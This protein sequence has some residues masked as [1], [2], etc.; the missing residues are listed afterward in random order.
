MLKRLILTVSTVLL[1][2]VFAAAQ[3]VRVTGSVK[4]ASDGSGLPGVT[5]LEQ[6]TTNGAISDIDGNY[7]L[8]VNQGATLQF[9][10]IGYTRQLVEVNGR[11]SI[12][13]MLEGESSVLNE[14]VV[15]AFGM[16]KDQKALGY[17]VTKIDGSDLVTAKEVSVASQLAGKVPGL[18]ITRPTTGPAGSTNIVIRGLGSLSGDNRAL[19]VVDGVPINN[20]NINSA[21]MWGGIDS[22]DGLSSINPDD[23][24]SVNVLKG[25]A[26]GALY[27]ERGAQGVIL[28][29]TKKGAASDGISLE[30]TTN[31][32]IDNAAIF[33]E[34]YQS[35]YGQGMNGMKPSTR[36]EAAQNPANWGARLDG[37]PMVYFDG[38]TR[39]YSAKA[40]DDLLNYYETGQTWMNTIAM[41]GGTE[42]VNARLSLSN[43]TNTGIVPNS[44][45]D[46][47]TVNLLT[48]LKLSE[49]L[50]LEM[51]ANYIQEEA[52][53]R[54]NL[55][56][57]PS[58]PGKAFSQLPN[59]ISVDMLQQRRFE[60]GRA[61]AWSANNPFT[62]NPYWGPFEHQQRDDKKRFIGYALGRYEFNDWISLQAR[63]AI[64]YTN[65][66]YF[67]AQAPGTEHIVQGSIDQ[68]NYETNDNTRDIILNLSPQLTEDI[69][70][71]VNLGGVQNPRSRYD[72]NVSGN[73]FIVSD[74]FNINNMAVRNPG[75]YRISELQ[76]NGLFGTALIDYRGVFFLDL[77]VRNDWYS[78]LTNPTDPDASQ[79][80]AL[81]GGASASIL[82]SEAFKMENET[83]TFGKFRVS[84]GV[85]GNGAPDPYLLLP[86]FSIESVP[87]NGASLGRVTSGTF[88]GSG[89]QP[90]ITKSF[91][92]GVDLRFLR[93]R[94]GLDLTYYQQNT[95]DQLF[96]ASLPRPTSFDRYFLNAGDVKNSGVEMAL[97]L[98]PIKKNDLRW[99][100][101]FNF[102]SNV[103]T[104]V[105][106]ADGIDN[107]S[108]ESARFNANLLSEVG[109]QVNS[110]YGT[111]LMRND[112]GQIIH[113]ESGL[114]MIAP[115][116]E[117]LG[118]YQPDWYGGL[119]NNIRYK[120]WNLGLLFDTKQGGEI[121]SITN[122]FSIGN[123]SHPMTLVGRDNPNFEIVGAGVTAG[124]G[125]NSTA[126]P[127]D[128]YY[129]RISNAAS[130]NIFDASYIKLR[131]ATLGYT[132]PKV[133][134]GGT[135]LRELS[136]SLTG[137]NLFFVQNG[138]DFLGLDPEAVYNIGGG[139][140][141]YSSIPST[142]SFGINL[143]VKL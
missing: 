122:Q 31:F 121:F 105:A 32:T 30:Y 1:L 112:A 119:N 10:Y 26:A 114:P 14:V 22:G 38:V 85:A 109:G 96:Q 34:Y 78:T 124:G 58:N 134:V 28:I 79:N 7:Y 50:T 68:T 132:F 36:E 127:L 18:D 40:S 16:K 15:T 55:S 120:N 61:I 63:Y 141:E 71:N 62:V 3:T 56:D 41:S 43:L 42:K 69:S 142:R 138:L 89:L 111:V 123:G 2:T 51:K 5:I 106:L 136:I 46:R 23:I 57:N 135:Q 73:T 48:S 84:Y 75:N 95:V 4:D 17:A 143:N 91:E 54:I 131:Q 76:T 80:S 21:G 19:I 100:V 29:T 125:A 45:Y 35:E 77:S 129:G 137:R 140:F 27:G 102:A 39:P 25:A 6:G 126:A 9:S 107:L 24:E 139:G 37:S 65:L 67:Y 66:D 11:T 86:T 47:Y 118:N 72:Y 8:T 94:I 92:V 116:R 13:V 130:E 74:L 93:N 82:F 81:Y 99:D 49:K 128:D 101:T 115:E 108:G 64:D 20:T 12:D 88:P 52:T 113:D 83:F 90:T 103:N 70:L 44:G 33:P 104:V 53:N 117:I 60:D 133:Q 87:F 97:N 98:T 110:I 59:N